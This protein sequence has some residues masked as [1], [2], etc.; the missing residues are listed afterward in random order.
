MSQGS[1]LTKTYFNLRH[2]AWRAL[3]AQLRSS[4]PDSDRVRALARRIEDA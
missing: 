2:D 1:F 3:A 4:L